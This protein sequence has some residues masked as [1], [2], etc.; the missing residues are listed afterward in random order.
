MDGSAASSGSLKRTK[1][2][3]RPTEEA[4]GR[5][6]EEGNASSA[7]QL[8]DSTEEDHDKREVRV[9][10]ERWRT[11]QPHTGRDRRDAKTKERGAEGD[12]REGR[13]GKGTEERELNKE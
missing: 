7:E 1:K 6:D 2:I 4:G 3:K 13:D 9:P 12:R 5:E 8:A 10:Q 11:E